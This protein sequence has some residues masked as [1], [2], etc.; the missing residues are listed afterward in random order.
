[1]SGQGDQ[2]IENYIKN[3]SNENLY[4]GFWVDS[5]DLVDVNVYW[6][7]DYLRGQIESQ[8]KMKQSPYKLRLLADLTK[9]RDRPNP[10]GIFLLLPKSAYKDV[11]FF[12][13]LE[14]QDD[15]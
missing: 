6:I 7:Y 8:K 14:N 4:Q 10:N 2:I 3:L 15:I 11:I 5:S 1:V 12:S 13:E 9:F